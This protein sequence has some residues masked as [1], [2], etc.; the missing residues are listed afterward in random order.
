MRTGIHGEHLMKTS[1]RIQQESRRRRSAGGAQR[2]F[3]LIEIMIVIAIIGILS[4]LAIPAYQEY[5]IRAQ[6]TEGLSLASDLQASV[7]EYYAQNG[8]WPADVTVLGL[9]DST[10]NS[11]YVQTISVTDGLITITYGGRANSVIADQTLALQPGLN[12]NEDVLWACGLKGAAYFTA[13]TQPP[14]GNA[15]GASETATTLSSRYL[16]QNCQG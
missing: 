6:V 2:G 8:V 14:N 1:E 15:A 9:P 11:N 5:T 4:G 16:P 10:R 3:T 13:F 7:A 12:D